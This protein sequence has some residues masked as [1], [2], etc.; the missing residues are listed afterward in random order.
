MTR[1]V[2]VHEAK[3]HLS[4][5]LDDVRAGEEIIIAKAGTPCARLVPIDAP[6]PRRLGF[7]PE[8]SVLA[9]AILVPLEDA[10]I[11]LY[12]NEL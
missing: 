6:G 7:R 2:N 9:D 5:L 8:L 3:T 4:R 11:D 12:E 1:S 10:E